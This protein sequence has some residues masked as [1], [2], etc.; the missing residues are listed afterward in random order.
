MATSTGGIGQALVNEGLINREQLAAAEAQRGAQGGSLGFNLALQG[1][2][3]E[4]EVARF[5][6]MQNGLEYVDL[7]STQVDPEALKL[8]SEATAV[9]TTLLPVTKKANALVCAVVEPG[10]DEQ[11]QLSKELK[12]KTRLGLEL[13]IAPESYI[14]LLIEHYYGQLKQMGIT[15]MDGGQASSANGAGASAAASDGQGAS[16]Y[17]ARTPPPQEQDL[18]SIM[19][20]ASWNTTS[21]GHA[22]VVMAIVDPVIG[23]QLGFSSMLSTPPELSSISKS[24]STFPSL[25][26][27]IRSRR[28]RCA[29]K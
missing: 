28:R 17:A 29:R 14:K 20:R 13:V 23:T 11:D 6:A 26:R 27:S 9:K 3:S 25:P 16:T 22:E 7:Q 2:I 1:A 8:V 15:A 19:E 12:F 24:V 21:A 10:S 5:I 18:T 4:E